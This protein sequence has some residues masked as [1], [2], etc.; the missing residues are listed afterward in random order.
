MHVYLVSEVPHDE[1]LSEERKK[2]LEPLS[3]PPKEEGAHIPLA[4]YK[5]DELTVAGNNYPLGPNKYI[6][7]KVKTTSNHPFQHA[8][9]PPR[10]CS[11]IFESQ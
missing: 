1:A 8:L 11:S 9:P 10:D 3:Q 5:A 2:Q 6:A 4:I 7:K